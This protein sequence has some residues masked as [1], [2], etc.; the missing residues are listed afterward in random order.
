MHGKTCWLIAYNGL[1]D[2]NGKLIKSHFAITCELQHCRIPV[3]SKSIAYR[4]I[5][6]I[7]VEQFKSDIYESAILNDVTG[8]VDE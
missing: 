3:K 4:N 5:N 6:N 7:N 1:Y 8:S 2:D